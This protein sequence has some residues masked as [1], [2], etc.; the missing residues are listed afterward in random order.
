MD[1]GTAALLA[2]LGSTLMSRGGEALGLWGGDPPPEFQAPQMMQGRGYTPPDPSYF[3]SLM[4]YNTMPSMPLQNNPS[5]MK[6]LGGY[7]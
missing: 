2:S 6:A 5:I 4:G 3:R 7:A 1:P